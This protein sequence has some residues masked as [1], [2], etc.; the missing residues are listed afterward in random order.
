M[1]HL[2]EAVA[3]RIYGKYGSFPEEPDFDEIQQFLESKGFKAASKE[4]SL[5][6]SPFFGQET[7]ERYCR[8]T[9]SNGDPY[10][11]FKDSKGNRFLLE[12]ISDTSEILFMMLE[13][14]GDRTWHEYDTYEK[15]RDVVTRHFGW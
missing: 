12:Q 3:K 10:I 15:F 13:R 9:G 1:E 6:T 14:K 7:G 11:V 5:G 2:N 4:Y 8:A